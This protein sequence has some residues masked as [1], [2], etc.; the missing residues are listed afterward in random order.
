MLLERVLLDG[1]IQIKYLLDELFPLKQVQ[2][3]RY[4]LDI[5]GVDLNL[6]RDDIVDVI[7]EM[8]ERH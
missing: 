6:S 2:P 8:R 1:E 3:T 7:R 5:V 4:P